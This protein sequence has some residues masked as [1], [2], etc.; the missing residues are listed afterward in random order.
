MK[1]CYIYL[2]YLK[3]SSHFDHSL[4]EYITNNLD[5]KLCMPLAVQEEKEE[6]DSVTVIALLVSKCLSGQVYNA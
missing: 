1:S 3:K 6:E 2:V 4:Y 5:S